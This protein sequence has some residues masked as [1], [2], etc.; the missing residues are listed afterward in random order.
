MIFFVEI[1]E[2]N[3]KEQLCILTFSRLLL[4]FQLRPVFIK[5]LLVSTFFVIIPYSTLMLQYQ[6]LFAI[7]M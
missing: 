4:A 7:A 5:W 2:F 3:R 1:I 6:Q